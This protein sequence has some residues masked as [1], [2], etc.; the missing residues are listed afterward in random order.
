MV[1][2]MGVPPLLGFYAKYYVIL[3]AIDADLLWLAVAVVVLL[4]GQRLLLP[5]R[6]RGDVL[7]PVRAGS[8]G[9]S[10]RRCSTPAS[11]VM[12]VAN[13]VLGLFSERL[14]D[15][16]DKWQETGTETTALVSGDGD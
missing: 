2:L 12:V 6:R 9:R 10:R 15:L 16:A 14:V 7:H 13:L 1:S 5:A 11:S 8:S 3:A 4:G